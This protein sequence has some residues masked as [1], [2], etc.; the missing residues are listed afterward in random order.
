MRTL[1][2]R[3]TTVTTVFSGTTELTATADGVIYRIQASDGLGT[4]DL[5]VSEVTGAEATAIQSG[6]PALQAGWTYRTFRSPGA[7]AGD[8]REFIRVVI[9]PAP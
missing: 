7:I 9:D 5:S 6:L 3:G 2:V 4:W 8:P 1:P